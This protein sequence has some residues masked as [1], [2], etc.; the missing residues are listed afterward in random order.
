MKRNEARRA[1]E[2]A[3][4][5]ATLTRA[6]CEYEPPVLNS[7]FRR[8]DDG[9][10]YRSSWKNDCEK[11]GSVEYGGYYS[12]RSFP[13]WSQFEGGTI[14]LVVTGYDPLY[15]YS[16][17]I[18]DMSNL[19][20]SDVACAAIATGLLSVEALSDIDTIL[21]V[22]VG[23]GASLLALPAQSFGSFRVLYDARIALHVPKG[24]WS[25]SFPLGNACVEETK[26]NACESACA[27]GKPDCGKATADAVY[28]RMDEKQRADALA[29]LAE[30][31]PFYTVQGNEMPALMCGIRKANGSEAFHDCGNLLEHTYRGELCVL[32]IPYLDERALCNARRLALTI[33]AYALLGAGRL[34]IGQ[35][36]NGKYAKRSLA[37]LARAC[38]AGRCDVRDGR[39]AFIDASLETCAP[40]FVRMR[41]LVSPAASAEHVAKARKVADEFAVRARALAVAIRVLASFNALFCTTPDALARLRDEFG[42][43]VYVTPLGSI[44]QHA[45]TAAKRWVVYDNGQER[46][47]SAA[48][49]ERVLRA[50]A[51]YAG[52]GSAIDAAA[53]GV[54][55]EDLCTFSEKPAA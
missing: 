33:E 35:V 12:D 51:E 43:T 11:R 46:K 15:D 19:F 9:G 22:S 30:I 44:G 27:P 8:N 49:A 39:A 37:V 55:V 7:V 53:L 16:A 23:Y 18:K 31:D 1:A 17:G 21:C 41:E 10:F 47:S 20:S 26:E 54:A 52:V 4:L 32:E 36:E 28:E 25:V 29:K 34:G 3:A 50:Y 14:A 40:A 48:E 38:T 6:R 5:F 2:R 45:S 13:Y 24:A 42:G